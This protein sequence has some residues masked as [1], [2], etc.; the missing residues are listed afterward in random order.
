GLHLGEAVG[1]DVAQVELVDERGARQ[2]F[3]ARAADPTNPDHRRF[4]LF[5]ARFP[6]AVLLECLP[7]QAGI[8]SP[9]T[10]RCYAVAPPRL[11]ETEALALAVE[12]KQAAVGDE[13][14][15]PAGA[16]DVVGARSR[17]ADEVDLLD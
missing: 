15:R 14:D 12:G 4:D 8:Q 7:P 6:F 17:R 1:L 16:I 13:R 5:H 3:G 9:L 2:R 11:A 10:N